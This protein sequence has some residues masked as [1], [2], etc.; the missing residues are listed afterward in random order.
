MKK[1]GVVIKDSVLRARESFE[2]GKTSDVEFRKYQLHQL[3]KGIYARQAEIYEALSLD[4]NKSPYESFMSEIGIVLGEIDF[5]IKRIE[6]WSKPKTVRPMLSQF[7]ALAKVYP[8]PYGVALIMSPWNYPF[9][10]TINPLI[11]AIAAGNSAILKPSSYSKHTSA[12]LKRLI[13]DYLDQDAYHV[14]IGGR[15]ENKAVLEEKFDVIFFTGSPK[16]GKIAMEAATKTLTPIVLELGGKS[17]T[18]VDAGADVKKAVKRILFG[19]LLN[20]GQTCVAPDYVLVDK[21]IKQSL[22]VELINEYQRMMPTR[23]YVIKHFPTI[24][25]QKHYDRIMGLLDD[26]KILY[27]AVKGSQRQI[28]F[29]IV[30]EP[31]LDS[32]IMQEE[33]FGPLLPIISYERLEDAIELIKKKD[34]PLA[35]YHF[36]RNRENQKRVIEEI[37]YGG[38]CINDTL[39]HLSSPLLP[40]GG[41]GNSGMGRYHG[42]AS[43]DA[44]TYQKSVL[45]KSLYLDLPLRY[46]PFKE[47]DKTPP[48]FLFKW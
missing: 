6:R 16:V 8:K 7:P 11:G 30:D 48:L 29:T 40:F 1:G 36:T 47:K 3:A 27:E 13:E 18:I 28:P 24:I 14:V 31:D 17:P 4:L 25:T 9:Q 45:K 38:G 37:N 34:R 43:F 39:I 22:V 19:K 5:A 12:C 32:P 41:V 23:E 42:K 33:I 46:H 10:L 35:L 20:A 44:F 2:S 26:Q 21:K 15:E